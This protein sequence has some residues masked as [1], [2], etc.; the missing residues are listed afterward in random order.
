VAEAVY[1]LAAEFGSAQWGFRPSRYTF[2]SARRLLCSY[3][4]D[5]EASLAAVDV[6]TLAVTPIATEFTEIGSL[7]AANDDVYFVGASPMHFPSIVKLSPTSAE[8]TIRKSS[9]TENVRA[10]EGYISVPQSIEFPTE[11]GLTAFGLFHPPVN[12][13]FIAPAAEL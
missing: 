10:Y 5:G 11:S 9:N 7:R 12:R 1:P 8:V 2:A 4:R 6:D 13:D 3:S